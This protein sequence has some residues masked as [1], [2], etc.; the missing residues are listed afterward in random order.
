[1]SY[2]GRICTVRS[3]RFC[4]CQHQ[5]VEGTDLGER[6]DVDAKDLLLFKLKDP[7]VIKPSRSLFQRIQSLGTNFSGFADEL[8]EPTDNVS[9]FWKLRPAN[10]RLHIFVR[11]SAAPLGQKRS[12]ENLSDEILQCPVKK[13][14]LDLLAGSGTIY[15]SEADTENC[16]DIP[17][18]PCNSN[19]H[20]LIMTPN[21][22]AA[23][24]TKYIEELDKE[25][26]Y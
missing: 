9:D 22:L 11:L 2:R 20:H 3:Y 7:M 13:P 8:D 14:R 6:R 23:D 10:D 12:A 18:L 16:N 19:F 21:I 1:V 25:P 24:K 15:Q 4:K 26:Q 17:I 5:P